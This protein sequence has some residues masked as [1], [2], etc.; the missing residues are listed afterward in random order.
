MN[1]EKAGVSLS[2]ARGVYSGTNGSK[3]SQYPMSVEKSKG[4]VA[5]YFLNCYVWENSKRRRI[6][7]I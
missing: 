1:K 6:D 5:G 7:I 2:D 3:A 4:V